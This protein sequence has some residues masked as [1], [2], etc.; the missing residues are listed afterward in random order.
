M[1]NGVT[2]CWP[3]QVA[4][5]GT[6]RGT[7]ERCP[8]N[9][10]VVGEDCSDEAYRRELRL[11]TERDMEEA[12]RAA[13]LQ[14][15]EEA[16]RAAAQR[17]EAARLAAQRAA[18]QAALEAKRRQE[19]ELAEKRRLQEAADQAAAIALLDLR[20][21]RLESVATARSRGFVFGGFGAALSIASALLFWRSTAAID[22]V[23]AGGLA[24]SADIS[25][26]VEAAGTFRSLSLMAGVGGGVMVMTG[27][28]FLLVAAGIE[29]PPLPGQ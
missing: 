11:R 4:T 20:N 6:C 18:Q 5:S 23:R 16:A 25:R 27:V 9:F 1:K 21:T 17:E 12:R 24:T 2:C 15:R 29:V 13:E 10:E 8:E 22:A 3:G 28:A 14:R 26:N 19:Q 7:P